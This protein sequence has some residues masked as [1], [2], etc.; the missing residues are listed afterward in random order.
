MI[1]PTLREERSVVHDEDVLTDPHHD[2]H[3]VVD[4]ENGQ[5]ALLAF[6]EQRSQVS[7]LLFAEAS[8][9]LVEYQEL[10]SD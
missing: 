8:E 6:A 7:G 2:F 9:G 10:W 1:W 5:A 4:K 3:V